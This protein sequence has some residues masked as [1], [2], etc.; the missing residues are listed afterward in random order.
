M[1]QSTPSHKPAVAVSLGA[2]AAIEGVA[3]LIAGLSHTGM[4]ILPFDEPRI[5]DAAI[6]E[7]LCGVL[8]VGSAVSVFARAAW[9]W[10]ALVVAH[11]FTLLGVLVGIGAIAAGLGPHSAFNDGYH[12]VTLVVLAAMLNVLATPPVRAAL[13]TWS[14]RGKHAPSH[15]V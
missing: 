9:A 6:V 8:L 14:E 12:R 11:A 13:R 5:V 3:F 1:I 2:F 15:P 7:G 4:R 10:L